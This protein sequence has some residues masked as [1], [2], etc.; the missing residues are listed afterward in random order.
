MVLLALLVVVEV[1]LVQKILL[2]PVLI[3]VLEVLVVQELLVV[4]VVFPPVS[5]PG[6]T[7]TGY[8]SPSSGGTS[9][10]HPRYSGGAGG[11]SGG[12][13]IQAWSNDKGGSGG[14][15]GCFQNLLLDTYQAM[16]LQGID[17]ELVVVLTPQ[18]A[19]E[20]KKTVRMLTD[21]VV[22]VV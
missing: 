19:V 22:S 11:G 16:F 5:T 9:P 14:A 21:K 17:N 20:V 12:S 6:G 3:V 8:A 13:A 10:S 15:A 18:V 4:Q 1:V 7:L 2:L